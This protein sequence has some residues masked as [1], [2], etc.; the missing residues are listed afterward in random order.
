LAY[1]NQPLPTVC[2]ILWIS[3]NYLRTISI[4]TFKQAVSPV[5]N[6]ILLL[7][8]TIHLP[9]HILQVKD[10]LKTNS[11]YRAVLDDMDREIIIDT[12]RK[13]EGNKSAAARMLNISRSAF[14]EKL[15]KYGIK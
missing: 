15:A 3:T 6:S 7:T 12:L 2:L 5:H 8:L 10:E 11:S 1:K 9:G 13:T 4:S 14:Y